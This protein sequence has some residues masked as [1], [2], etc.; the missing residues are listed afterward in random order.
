MIQA[1]YPIAS[2]DH[3]DKPPQALSAIL[4]SLELANLATANQKGAVSED[5]LNKLSL[6]IPFVF[7]SF[8]TAQSLVLDQFDPSSKI[9]QTTKNFWDC[10]EPCKKE[11]QNSLNTPKNFT[12][13]D[14]SVQ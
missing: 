8:K 10:L 9:Y 11:L 1:R 3:Y 5:A 6:L 4:F 12:I 2:R 14:W 13:N 7:D